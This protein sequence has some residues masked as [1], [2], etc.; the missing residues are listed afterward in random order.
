M[1]STFGA[2]ADGGVLGGCAAGQVQQGPAILLEAGDGR[3]EA[4]VAL[5]PASR[6]GAVPPPKIYVPLK[7]GGQGLVLDVIEEL[8]A[9]FEGVLAPGIDEVVI[10]LRPDLADALRADRL[11]RPR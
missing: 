8:Q 9:G 6:T 10:P 1:K 11:R 7:V 4:A 2:A 5:L 3:S